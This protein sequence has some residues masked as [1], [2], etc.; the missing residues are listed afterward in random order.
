MWRP[1]AAEA[2][3]PLTAAEREFLILHA[4]DL[5]VR[6]RTPLA[7]LT[8]PLLGRKIGPFQQ[9]HFVS[10]PLVLALVL[11]EEGIVEIVPPSWLRPVELLKLV[12]DEQTRA[13]LRPAP[14]P[15]YIVLSRLL[16][17]KVGADDWH[18]KEAAGPS[19]HQQ[20]ELL[21]ETYRGIR[22]R[23]MSILNE[24]FVTSQQIFVSH[25]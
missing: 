11:A 7:R 12:R 4:Y 23:K 5:V 14:D 2:I 20:I 17:D 13:E 18:M 6:F 10:L 19:S 16:L 9:G 24:Q 21:L 15:N 8:V 3:G 22:E 25:R 1:F